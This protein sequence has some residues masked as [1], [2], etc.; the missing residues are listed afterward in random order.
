MY[1]GCAAAAPHLRRF[2]IGSS[3]HVRKDTKETVQVYTQIDS[4]ICY[5]AMVSVVRLAVRDM[6]END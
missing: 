1:Q 4:H 2:S 3:Q 6:L 5:T